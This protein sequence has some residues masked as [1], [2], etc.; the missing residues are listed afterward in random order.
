MTDFPNRTLDD[1]SESSSPP[2]LTPAPLTKRMIAFAMDFI[3]LVLLLQLLAHFMPKFWDIHTQEEFQS[4]LH[5]AT[6]L[7]Q[8]EQMDSEQMAL[9]IEQSGLSPETY[10]MLMAMVVWAC[11]LPILYFFIGERFFGGKSLGKATFGLASVRMS[12]DGTP[13]TPMRQFFR[14]LLKGLSGLILITPFLLPGLM[15]FLFCL[16]NKHRRCLHD[17]IAGTI[18]IQEQKQKESV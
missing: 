3:L 14:T 10:E 12:G 9:F 8:D 16:F 18:T 11:F 5:Q 4:L 17:I 13:P 7:P 6:L 1:E 2:I 15:N